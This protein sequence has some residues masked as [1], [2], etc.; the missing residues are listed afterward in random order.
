MMHFFTLILQEYFLYSVIMKKTRYF[1]FLAGMAFLFLFSCISDMTEEEL[2]ME[3]EVKIETFLDKHDT[4]MLELKESGLY[5][6]EI[7]A[8]T[9]N[10]PETQDSVF[11]FYSLKFLSGTIIESNVGTKDTLKFLAGEGEAL[12]GLDEGVSYMKTG[13]ESL[14]LIPSSLAYGSDG[15]AGIGPYTPILINVKLVRIK[16]P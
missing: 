11:A 5:Y 13:G 1:I 12:A 9:G 16:K 10:N 2:K 8:G 7:K 14:L 4:L 6:R 15:K 3:E